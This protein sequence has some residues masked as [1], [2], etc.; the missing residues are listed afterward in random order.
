M[1]EYVMG[2][3]GSG[4][5]TSNILLPVII[6]SVISFIIA[7]IYLAANIKLYTKAGK[8]WWAAIIPIYNIIVLMDIANLK[9]TNLLFLLIPIL[10]III[11]MIKLNIGIA[12]RFNKGTGYALGLIFLPII[13]L[14]LLAFSKE[15]ALNKSV[16]NKNMA[17]NIEQINN[18]NSL[19]AETEINS[20][21]SFDN[22]NQIDVLQNPINTEINTNNTNNLESFSQTSTMSSDLNTMNQ[23]LNSQNNF[24]MESDL[25]M[26]VLNDIPVFENNNI[27]SNFEQIDINQITNP[28]TINEVNTFNQFS[29]NNNATNEAT[30]NQNIIEPTITNNN[31]MS[32]NNISNEQNANPNIETLSVEQ[33]NNLFYANANEI[34]DLNNKTK[35]NFCKN[36]GTE[37]PTI[38]TIC[39]KCGTENE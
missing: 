28:N 31:I 7:I 11:F 1:N 34:V 26:E 35:G 24:N 22:I 9:Y 12:K 37:M 23:S 29:I 38:V 16:E 27:S 8:P 13:F 25:N 2:G 21:N 39:P 3:M 5:D 10:G 6:F 15:E 4:F 32:E 20:N 18:I 30:N 14:P 17:N 36:C 19:N 33:P